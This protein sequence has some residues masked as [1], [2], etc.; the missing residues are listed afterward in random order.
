MT[1][2]QSHEAACYRCRYPNE[3]ALANHVQH[4]RNVYV[5]ERDI[6]PALDNWLLKASAPHRITDTIR[7]LHAAQPEAGPGTVVAPK[8]TS[9]A[10][11][12]P[13]TTSAIPLRDADSKDK[14]NV[15]R[16]LRLALTYDPDKNKISVEAKPDADYCGVTVRV[17]GGT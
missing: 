4:P 10:S 14:S 8:T 12:A 3:Y 15:Y 7:R 5:A 2:S 17:R 9:D 13:S 6:V 1:E 16:E 11:S